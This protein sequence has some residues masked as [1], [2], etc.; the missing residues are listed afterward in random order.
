M[1]HVKPDLVRISP[2]V[3]EVIWSRGIK[4]PPRRLKVRIEVREEEGVKVAV[5]RLPEADATGEK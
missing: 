2:E 3:N 1:R 4:R 5:V